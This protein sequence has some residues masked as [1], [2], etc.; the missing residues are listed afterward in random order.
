VVEFTASVLAWPRA[1]ALTLL[2][3][4]WLGFVG[5]R[6][7]GPPLAARLRPWP[8]MFCSVVL[9]SV[10][11]LAM[12]AGSLQSDVSVRDA[13]MWSTSAV[14]GLSAGVFV[15]ASRDY[16][17][18]GKSLDAM[19]VVGSSL[20]EATVPCLAAVLSDVHTTPSFVLAA[21]CLSSGGALALTVL[22]KFAVERGGASAAAV[23]RHFQLVDSEDPESMMMLPDDVDDEAELLSLA[24]GVDMETPVNN[25]NVSAPSPR[26]SFKRNVRSNTRHD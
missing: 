10:C 17:P 4:F 7:L 1:L 16:L 6:L 11:G 19:A 21:V 14:L 5:G 12:L 24:D 18:A 9:G 25:N 15:P 26:Q 13:L 20:G 22:L 2:L 23:A 8:V 3:T